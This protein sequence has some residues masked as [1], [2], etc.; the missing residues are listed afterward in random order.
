MTLQQAL[1]DYQ[2]LA[3]RMALPSL[4]AGRL[5]R[6]ATRVDTAQAVDDAM[7][8]FNPQQG[9]LQYQS[10]V[11][12]LAEQQSQQPVRAGRLLSAELVSGARSLHVQWHGPGWRVTE[13][14]D[15]AGDTVAVDHCQLLATNP[16][17]GK[18]E[19]VRYWQLDAHHGLV[20][21]CT[22][23]VGFTAVGAA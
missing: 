11:V 2:V 18:L 13:Y 20:P 14:E 3:Q 8:A 1:A 7:A 19:Y 12:T 21:F 9:W 16:A 5:T 22:R 4:V 10:A 17:L 15:G 23:F 6:T